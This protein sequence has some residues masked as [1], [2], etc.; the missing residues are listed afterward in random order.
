M[1]NYEKSEMK[2]A[3]PFRPKLAD[4]LKNYSPQDF[5]HE[6]ATGR[7]SN[8]VARIVTNYRRQG[9]W[10]RK[11]M[12][13]LIY[14]LQ[15]AGAT[16]TRRTL[17]RGDD[18][19]GPSVRCSTELRPAGLWSGSSGGLVVPAG[20]KARQPFRVRLRLAGRLCAGLSPA[21]PPWTQASAARTQSFPWTFTFPVAHQI[22]SVSKLIFEPSNPPGHFTKVRHIAKWNA[23][24]NSL[25][26]FET[27]SNPHALLHGI[28]LA[29]GRLSPL[30]LS[31]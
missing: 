2:F 7:Q 17:I 19:Y 15:T 9:Q 27:V 1:S 31:A 29:M 6:I 10:Q 20:S 8:V 13:L 12:D 5:H 25:A 23:N 3:I 28:L 24:E 30:P 18:D 21:P 26:S 22:E 11:V 16:P 4:A 14:C